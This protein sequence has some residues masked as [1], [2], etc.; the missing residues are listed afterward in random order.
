MNRYLFAL[1]IVVG[2]LLGVYIA[3]SVIFFAVWKL[4]SEEF[5][6]SGI[7]GVKPEAGL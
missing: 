7:V 4:K 6:S 2:I 5:S 3:F 1:V